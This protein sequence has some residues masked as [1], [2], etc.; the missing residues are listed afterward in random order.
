MA[1]TSKYALLHVTADDGTIV[2]FIKDGDVKEIVTPDCAFP[3]SVDGVSDY[4]KFVRPSEHGV[5]TIEIVANGIVLQKHVN[6]N[7]N[8][9][10]DISFDSTYKFTQYSRFESKDLTDL[11]PWHSTDGRQNMVL[12][13]GTWD[14]S[15]GKLLSH[16]NSC[17]RTNTPG[18]NV[19]YGIRCSVDSFTPSTSGNWYRQHSL[20]GSELSGTQKDYAVTL[21]KS[22]NIIYPCIGY[23]NSSYSM[24]ST[25]LP[26]GETFELYLMYTGTQ[27]TMYLNGQLIHTLNYTAG[28]SAFD[29]IGIFW[30][31]EYDTNIVPGAIEA[32]GIWTFTRSTGKELILPALQEL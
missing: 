29:T 32:F 9:F 13:K 21:M 20:F 10:Y 1:I 26:I 8:E 17:Y 4:Y 15:D 3:N 28:G 6:V 5:W 2:K 16:G 25:P 12:V 7:T 24:S 14:V 31:N 22:N 18:T 30:Q 19:L 11:A 23:A 27:F